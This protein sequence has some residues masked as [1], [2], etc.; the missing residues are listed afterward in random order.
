MG[1]VEHSVDVNVPVQVAYNQWTQFEE[2]PRFMDGV[3]KVQQLDDKRL[4]W[5]AEIWGVRKD[6]EA[7]ITEQTPDQRIAWTA[8]SGA[9]NAG[10]VDFH[11]ISDDKTRV[12][13]TMDVDPDGPIENIGDALG[14]LDRRVKGDMERFKEF[15]ES[16]GTETGAWR[17]EIQQTA[18]R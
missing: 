2:F 9:T 8:T 17:G 14:I 16:R 12:T 3:E 18:V 7:E 6:W 5:V 15:I 11:R 1:K 4:H 10:S 13:L